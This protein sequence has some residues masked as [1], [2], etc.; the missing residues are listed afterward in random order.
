MATEYARVT[1]VA[2]DV[3]DARTGEI[4]YPLGTVLTGVI[5]RQADGL[6]ELTTEAGQTFTFREGTPALQI[7]RS[8][9][10]FVSDT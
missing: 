5:T 7:E 2:D 6:V 1:I 3:R 10:A 8:E 9:T 4:R